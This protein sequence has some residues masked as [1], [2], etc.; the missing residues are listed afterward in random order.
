MSLDKSTILRRWSHCWMNPVG[1]SSY[2][3]RVLPHSNERQ[4]R[5]VCFGKRWGGVQISPAKVSNALAETYISNICKIH[6][7]RDFL[8]YLRFLMATMIALRDISLKPDQSML[9]SAE[10]RST[11]LNSQFRHEHFAKRP[12]I[13]RKIEFTCEYTNT[14]RMSWGGKM[15]HHDKITGFCQLNKSYIYTVSV[16][17]MILSFLTNII[18]NL[19]DLV[20]HND[21]LCHSPCHNVAARYRNFGSPMGHCEETGDSQIWHFRQ[22]IYT[23]GR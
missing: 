8:Q 22:G 16:P 4:V 13:R 7:Y 5:I 10:H 23:G 6:I 18:C 2:A 12:Q 14:P 21:S 11:V 19:A 9:C 20:L 3:S 15:N 1:A 17:F